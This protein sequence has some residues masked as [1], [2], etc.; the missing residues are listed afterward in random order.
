MTAEQIQYT[1]NTVRLILE[2][3]SGTGYVVRCVPNGGIFTI[4]PL[5]EGITRRGSQ[6]VTR[7]AE[8]IA[9]QGV[10]QIVNEITKE[11]DQ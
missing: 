3:F 7:T 11:W 8:Q 5:T 6:T 10:G 2:A 4:A 9:T 1:E